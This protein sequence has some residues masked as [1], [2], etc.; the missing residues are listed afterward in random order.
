MAQ[1]RPCAMCGSSLDADKKCDCQ[2]DLPVEDFDSGEIRGAGAE[3]LEDIGEHSERC[4]RLL[5][6]CRCLTCTRDTNGDWDKTACCVR[7]G[8]QCNSTKA[9]AD[10]RAEAEG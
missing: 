9:C 1:Y 4:R 5:P 10:Y 2:M 3:P 6:K 7:H 8:R